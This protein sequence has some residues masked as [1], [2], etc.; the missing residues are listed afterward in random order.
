VGDGAACG[1]RNHSSYLYQWDGASLLFDCGEPVSRSFKATGLN[2]DSIDR[3]FLSHLHSDHVGGFFMLMQ[4]FWLERRSKNLEVHLPADAIAPVRQMLRASYLFDDLLPFQLRF[5][6]L[7]EGKQVAQGDL[8]VTP[9]RTSHLEALRER[10]QRK[11]PGDYAAY[12]FLIESKH[13][14]IGHSAD[15]GA[16]ED[17]EPLLR[18]PLDLLVCELAHFEPAQLFRYLRGREIS[19]VVF[20]HLGRPHWERLAQT[21]RLATQLLTGVP[22]TFAR[23]QQVFPL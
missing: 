1:N 15:L 23:D 11:F 4:G 12:S 17:L 3:I 19:R 21:R 5:V 16:P 13:R 14:R 6:P 20:S 2:Y 18:Q 9:Y 10:F 7:R 22:F 8:R